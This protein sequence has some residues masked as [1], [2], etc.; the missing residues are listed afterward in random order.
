M[1]S[2]TISEL[3]AARSAAKKKIG[4]YVQKVL[5]DMLEETGVAPSGVSVS[6]RVHRSGGVPDAIIVTDV[7][8]GLEL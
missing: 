3:Q 5:A 6:T 7:I 8:I 1:N 4:V 2:V